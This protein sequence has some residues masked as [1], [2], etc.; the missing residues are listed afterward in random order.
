MKNKAN[1]PPLPQS[2]YVQVWEYLEDG[3]W[4]SMGEAFIPAPQDPFWAILMRITDWWPF[5]DYKPLPE[6]VE[7]FDIR[8]WQANEWQGASKSR[9]TLVPTG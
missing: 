9:A 1:P 8:P 4:S 2:A 3:I 7:D 6:E 5:L